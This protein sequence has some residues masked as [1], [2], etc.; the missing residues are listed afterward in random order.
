MG[1]VSVLALSATGACGDELFDSAQVWSGPYIG[2]HG[3]LAL[4]EGTLS[5]TP[6]VAG[7]GTRDMNGTG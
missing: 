5:F 2:A 7:P 4:Q 3:G 1:A 6:V